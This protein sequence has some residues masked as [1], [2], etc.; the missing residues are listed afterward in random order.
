M[1][2]PAASQGSDRPAGPT[3]GPGPDFEERGSTEPRLAFSRLFHLGELTANPE[4]IRAAHAAGIQVIEAVLR[5]LGGD[6]GDVDS[7]ASAAN[8]N[9][10]ATGG[11]RSPSTGRPAPATL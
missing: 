4:A 11:A 6:W 8:S 2:T 5:H 7:P 10:V 1:H 3:S 9:A